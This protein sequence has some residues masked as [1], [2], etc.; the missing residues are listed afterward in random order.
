MANEKRT[1]RVYRALFWVGYFPWLVLFAQLP[2]QLELFAGLW[3]FGLLSATLDR[4]IFWAYVSTWLEMGQPVAKWTSMWSWNIIA[5]VGGDWLPQTSQR[6]LM[7]ALLGQA[8]LTG[9]ALA[10]HPNMVGAAI[11]GWLHLLVI[12]SAAIL[13]SGTYAM[14]DF[15]TL[16]PPGEQPHVGNMPINGQSYPPIF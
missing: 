1:F 4:M 16:L 8:V 3:Y 13:E 12:T 6:F 9:W 5:V 2:W 14:A 7:M 10:Q 11:A 15:R